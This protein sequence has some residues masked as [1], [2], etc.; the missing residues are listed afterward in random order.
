M[1]TINT[2]QDLMRVLD[3]NP[4]WLEAMRSRLL[5]R[6]LLELPDRFTQLSERVAQLSDRLTQL[7]EEV[8]AFAVEMRAFAA[9]TDR[10]FDIIDKRF[11]RMDRRFD[12]METSIGR[13]KGAYAEGRVSRQADIIAEQMGFTWVRTWSYEDI[14]D[15]VQRSNRSDIPFG[16]IRSFRDADIIMES[17]DR[18]GDTHYI[19]VEVSFTADARDTNRA[20]RNARLMKRFTASPAHPAVAGLRKD[21]DILELFESGTIHWYQL[22]DEDFEAH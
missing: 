3:E 22:D 18:A 21:D 8:S 7:S 14:R 5:S 4:E 9:K 11:D 16:D 13:M 19:P 10:R 12:R 1:T 2:V 17:T 15:L 20:L 6:E